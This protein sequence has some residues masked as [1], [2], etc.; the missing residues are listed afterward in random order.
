MSPS[1]IALEWRPQ[2]RKVMCGGREPA[3][4]LE[5]MAGSRNGPSFPRKH[6]SR[7]PGGSTVLGL[8]CSTRFIGTIGGRCIGTI[9]MVHPG[10]L[11]IGDSGAF[12]CIPMKIGAKSEHCGHKH[13]SR[14]GSA[15]APDQ[16]GD[17]AAEAG[18]L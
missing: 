1:F 7:H 14:A 17:A 5:T 6:G 10:T 11:F 8:F 12:L 2:S 3:M 18:G 9:G 4:G 13:S 15:L 16:P